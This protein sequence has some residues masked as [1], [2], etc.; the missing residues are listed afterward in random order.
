MVSEVSVRRLS[1]ISKIAGYTSTLG[2]AVLAGH[3]VGYAVAIPLVGV[4]AGLAKIAFASYLYYQYCHL[5]K[6]CGDQKSESGNKV[7][8]IIFF[9]GL[10]EV[11]GLGLP[12]LAYDV[13][14][15]YKEWKAQ[16]PVAAKPQPT[17]AQPT[18][19]QPKAAT[20]I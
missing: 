11:C 20:S 17:P 2:F 9:R 13:Y 18:P 6:A 1:N 16:Q 3:I 4:I 8:G 12:W 7:I 14:K 10:T 19:G 5:N 15:I